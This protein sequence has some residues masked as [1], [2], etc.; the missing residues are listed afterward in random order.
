MSDRNMLMAEEEAGVLAKWVKSEFLPGIV[1]RLRSVDSR[2]RLGL[3][4]DERVPENERNLTDVRNRVSLIL[5]YEFARQSNE[6]LHEDG[7][8]DVFLSYVVANRF[9]DL[10]FRGPGGECGIRVE[11][12]CIQSIA[13]EPAANFSTLVKDIDP[14][15]DFVV[16]LLWEW[17]EE[18][19]PFSWD[20]A[21][22]VLDGYAFHASSLAA[23]R[24]QFWLG[25]PGP[26][27]QPSDGYQGFDIR[28]A[29]T[30]SRTKGYKQ[31]ENNYGKLLRLWRSGATPGARWDPLVHSELEEYIKFVDQ[32]HRVGFRSITE[33]W[34]RQ[35][36]GSDELHALMTGGTTYGFTS[37]SVAFV[38]GPLL[39]RAAGEDTP[40]ETLLSVV[41]DFQTV[42]EFGARFKWVARPS[43]GTARRKPKELAGMV[44]QGQIGN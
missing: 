38:S 3:Y 1:E 16:V 44:N 14:N 11:M 32:T 15:R 39:E 19:S 33:K 4:N 7:I 21:P 43:D 10:E 34:I 18:E 12:K 35:I 28:E 20:R 25:S 17:D 37:G 29:I 22:L 9:P 26:G 42:I 27:W 6:L 2:K 13:E 8:D 30:Y 5:E 31:E 41:D 23:I 36:S 40:A 24:D